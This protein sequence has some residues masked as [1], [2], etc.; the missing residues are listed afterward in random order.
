MGPALAAALLCAPLAPQGGEVVFERH[1]L[2]GVFFGEG[3]AFGDLDGDGRADVVSGPYW[4]AGPDFGQRFEL[5]PPQPFDPLHYSDFFFAWTRDLDG[6]RDLD[7]LAVGF[8]GQAAFWLENPGAP[9]AKDAAWARHLVFPAVDNESPALA[10]LLG[11][12]APE[13]VFMSEGRFGYAAPDPADPRAPWRFTP[14]S[15]E[16]E[17]GPFVH[18]LGVG[19]LDGDGR[20]DVLHKGGWLEQPAAAEPGAPWQHHAFDFA[21]GGHG[22]AQ[23]LVLD[24]DGDGDAD[25][26]TSLNAHGYGLSLF[27]QTAPGEFAE[28][29]VMD[30]EPRA[31]PRGWAVSELHALAL[32]DV[33][34]DGLQD[35]ITGKRYWAH[36]PNGAGAGDPPYLLWFKL[37]RRA[38]NA[39]T[40]AELVPQAIDCASGVGTQ[41]TAGD[42]DGDGRADVVVGNKLGTFVFLQRPGGELPRTPDGRPLNL[43]FERGDL[44]DWRAEGDAF[45]GQ[46]VFGDKPTERD[47]EPARLQ[48][49]AWIGGYELLGDAPRGRLVSAPFRL[50]APYASF[51]VGGGNHAGTRVE[52]ARFGQDEAFFQTSGANSETMQR[53]VADL[54]S[55]RGALVE[56]RLVDEESGGWGHI[57]FDDFRLHAERPSFTPDPR[58]PPIL[59]PDPVLHAGLSPAEAARAM[60]LAPGFRADVI[61]AEPDL[62]Q[63]IAFTIDPR[64]R[65]WVVEAFSYPAKQPPGAGRDTILV[66]EDRDGDARFETRTVFEDDLNLVS[67]IEV[68]FGGVWVGQAPE[69]LFIPDRD[70]DLRPDGP[71]EV[72]LDGFGLEDTHETLNTFTWGP[73][74]W[75]YGCHGVFTHSRVGQPGTPDAERVPLN[76]GVWRYHPTR[77]EFEVFAEGTSNPWGLDFDP[78]GQAFITACVIPHLYHVAQGG[79]YERQ[80][81]SHFEPY[82]YDDIKTIAD[83][84]HYLGDTPWNGNGRSGAAGG[85][86]AHCGALI[87]QADAFP[88]EWRGRIFMDNIHGNRLNTD[89][90][91][92]SGSGF[93]GGHGPDFLLAN[94]AWFRAVHLATGPD[95]ALYLSDWYDQQACHLSDP[96]RW[97]R[98]NGRLYRVSYGAPRGFEADLPA[99]DDAALAR[100]QLH[101]N[102]WFAR[103]ARMLLQERGAG[104]EALRILRTVLARHDDEALRLRALWTLHA[105]GGIDAE[106]AR[107]AARDASEYVRAWLIQLALER[108]GSVPGF[109]LAAFLADPSP[110]VRLYLASALQRLPPAERWPVAEALLAHAEDAG[111]RNLPYLEWYGVEPLVA[112]DPERALALSRSARIP[113]VAR[114]IVRRAAEEPRLLEPLVRALGA[115]ADPARVALMLEEL[116][117][118]LAG[119]RGVAAPESWPAVHAHLLATAAPEQ[120]GRLQAV[121]AALGDRAGFPELRRMLA[122]PS[123]ATAERLRA[124]ATLERGRDEEL[125]PV[126]YALL[127][128]EALR[129]PALR[130][131]ASY[132][133]PA[134]PERVLAAYP[135]C[136]AEERRD[137]LN[138]L[139][140]RAPWA[141]ALL[142]AVEGGAVPRTDV[143]AFVVRQI[144]SHGD[145]ELDRLLASA[146]GTVRATPADKAQ[147][148]AELKA[149]LPPEVLAQA[150]LPRGRAL[151]AR[152]CGQCHAL[153]GAGGDV[154]PDLTGSNRADL[155]YLLHNLV[156]PS[157]EVGR[158]YRATVVWLKDGRIATGILRDETP[159]AF[160]LRT[161][162]EALVLAR[163]DVDEL[164]P[165]DLSTMPDGLLD[166]LAPG[167]VRDLVAYL[168]SP[169]QVPRLLLPGDEALLF[170][171]R[172]LAG[173]RGDPALWSVADGAIVGRSS[174]LSENAF[175]RSEALLR[176]FRLTLSVQLVGDAG[177][178]GIQFRSRELEGGAVTGYQADVGPGWWGRLYEE[179]GRG[180]LV[181]EGAEAAVRPGEWNTY[182]ITAVGPRVLLAINGAEAADLED[183]AGAREGILALQLHAGG[184]MEIRFKDLRLELDPVLPAQER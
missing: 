159:S 134:T 168:A 90:L 27:E 31:N 26:V 88:K 171:G 1:A 138:T 111:D 20:A 44:S 5:Y 151:F 6:D 46:P 73:D 155:D 49:D 177:N 100:L 165:S 121:S 11:D 62:Q 105:V 128:D 167:D 166:A 16:V 82:T 7:V 108:P 104:P 143:G 77:R 19:D 129:G 170:D 183:A 172:T 139:A 149:A 118:A 85:G 55:E 41:V 142:S 13:L 64:G 180:L 106:T 30:A 36:G 66:L 117:R 89:V 18:G 99:L 32:A 91:A 153:F 52:L 67:G 107:A 137:A 63:P 141:L 119:Q 59:P 133:D 157:A 37:A 69:L 23:M 148:A 101:P 158:D 103:R 8:P 95:G 54:G 174:G 175:L 173:W 60:T 102:E 126:L 50:N 84:L 145:P 131:L 113:F 114:S 15:E 97:D 110:V 57:N 132:D 76:A 162:N 176:D 92:R 58:V 135:A 81:G 115:E 179:L 122:D 169:L 10:D 34:G 9:R 65:I 12:P 45:R 87:Y 25:V 94:D 125:V 127:G 120:A 75:L 4:Y 21:A 71:P 3:A 144:A 61:A 43:D 48:G 14:I 130:A 178:S 161:E 86:H 164:R 160:A 83:H 22:G 116:E 147:R 123:A 136:G 68:G 184:P 109:D 124:L 96:L 150:D 47:R 17:R 152:T 42:V 79:R 181:S 39:R 182:T 40:L 78:H 56:I 98:T 112:L 146:W 28:Q 33:D 93:S 154:G 74:G 72:L 53:V 51:L 140:S 24:A 163:S 156:D 38:G 70:D 35:V 2:S 80:S 29:R